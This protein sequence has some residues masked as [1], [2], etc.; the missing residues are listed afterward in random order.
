METER[1]NTKFYRVQDDQGNDIGKVCIEPTG[2]G[3]IVMEAFPGIVL[4]LV[5]KLTG[6]KWSTTKEG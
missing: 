1:E 5:P 3:F 6:G 4:R 2:D